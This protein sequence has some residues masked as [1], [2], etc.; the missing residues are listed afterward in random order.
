VGHETEGIYAK[1]IDSLLPPVHPDVFFVRGR[2]GQS[3]LEQPGGKNSRAPSVKE[4]SVFQAHGTPLAAMVK[5]IRP[6][7]PEGKSFPMIDLYLFQGL[8]GNYTEP[9]RQTPVYFGNYILTKEGMKE[10]GRHKKS[11]TVLWL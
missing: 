3:H 5:N 8:S 9:W 4:G 7:A 10:L 1:G 11:I 6:L 2:I